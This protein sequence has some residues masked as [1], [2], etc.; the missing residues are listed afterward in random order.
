MTRVMP[1][2][3]IAIAA[4]LFVA[5]TS[6]AQ[7]DANLHLETNV[8][9]QADSTLDLGPMPKTRGPLAMWLAASASTAAFAVTFSVFALSDCLSG[10]CEDNDAQVNGTFA[11][12]IISASIALTGMIWWIVRKVQRS[13][14][15]QAQGRAA[16]PPLTFRW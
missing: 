16:A 13:R 9:L 2:Y 3:V 15:S 10:P 5:S 14:W 8:Q 4:L 7:T 12:T 11:A 6:E 1:A